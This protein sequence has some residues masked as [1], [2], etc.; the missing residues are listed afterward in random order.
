[1]QKHVPEPTA[2]ILVLRRMAARRFLEAAHLA[3]DLYTDENGHA[4]VRQALVDQIVEASIANGDIAQAQDIADY[5]DWDILPETKWKVEQAE[6][7]FLTEDG[8]EVSSS[9][10]VTLL[11]KIA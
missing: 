10:A 3:H 7:D 4:V 9:Q 6:G 1:M 5:Y 8:T 2:S 11:R